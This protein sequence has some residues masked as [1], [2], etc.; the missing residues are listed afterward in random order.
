MVDPI[1]TKIKWEMQPSV[2]ARVARKRSLSAKRQ[3]K[4]GKSL[5]YETVELITSLLDSNN[6]FITKL[7]SY[8]VSINFQ[9]LLIY[10]SISCS[11]K[12]FMSTQDDGTDHIHTCKLLIFTLVSCCW[13]S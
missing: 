7:H 5:N 13:F 6:V 2:L 1:K 9:A 12:L 11:C 3:R 10:Y 8:F 4:K